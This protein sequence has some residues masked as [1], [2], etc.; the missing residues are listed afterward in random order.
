MYIF[1]VIALLLRV[2][3]L[4]VKGS[5][6]HIV[7]YTSLGALP[8]RLDNKIMLIVW[9]ELQN[10]NYASKLE[11]KCC[12]TVIFSCNCHW[13][14]LFV[15]RFLQN[16]RLKDL[17]H[18]IFKH[19]TD[20]LTLWVDVYNNPS[21]SYSQKISASHLTVGHFE[22]MLASARSPGSWLLVYWIHTAVKLVKKKK[23]K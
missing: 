17:P 3:I 10:K 21:Q 1:R 6:P 2:I 12:W 14:W 7:F 20:L 15:D 8:R 19:I 4:I 23:V 13:L 9:L 5:G 16:N 11:I 18:D 22:H